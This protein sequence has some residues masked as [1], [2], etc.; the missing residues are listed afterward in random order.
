METNKIKDESLAKFITKAKRKLNKQICEPE[1]KHEEQV[2][3]YDKY[4]FVESNRNKKYEELKEKVFEL[5]NKEPN[6]SSPLLKLVE[7]NE[8]NHL[9]DSEKERYIL[10]LSKKYVEFASQ[11][12]SNIV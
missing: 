12:K 4:T 9:S 11:Q 8:Y 10:K 5:L 2:L 3:L 6:T 7:P 1:E